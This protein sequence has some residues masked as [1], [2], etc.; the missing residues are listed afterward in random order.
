M[1]N[2]FNIPNYVKYVLN[3][4][5]QSGFNA[6]LV[7]GCVR[8]RLMGLVPK[9]WDITTNALPEQIM[10]IF[11]NCVPTGL[12]HGTVT[13]VLPDK[14]TIEVTTFRIDGKYLDS[15]R[16]EN[17]YFSK[18]LYEDL[19]RRDFTMNAI[20]WSLKEGIVDPF[21]GR[22]DIENKIIRCVGE[23]P[24]RFSEDALRMMRAIRFAAVLNFELHPDIPSAILNLHHLLK[25][26]SAERV[27][28]EFSK[29][30]LSD[31]PEKIYLYKSLELTQYFLPECA[32]IQDD[33][34]KNILA[35]IHGISVSVHDRLAYLLYNFTDDISSVMNRL[36]YDNK[37]CYKVK[38]IAQCLKIRV[39]ENAY[40]MRLMMSD[41]LLR[42]GIKDSLNIRKEVMDQEEKPS[43]IYA[44]ELYDQTL[45]LN[46]CTEISMLAVNGN[47]LENLGIKDGK[48]K[49]RLLK[50]LLDA[51]LV[52]P[53]LNIYESL[54]NI[55]H[56]DYN[57]TS[58]D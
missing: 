2:D 46:H 32:N 56:R 6:Y 43:I 55:L 5:E 53:S 36:K 27:R 47:D 25:N 42:N 37:T 34:L 20:A 45:K 31:N 11:P 54:V 14:N 10:E 21:D 57:Y 18:N 8:D 17:V 49:G 40:E 41:K 1:F 29:T 15:R 9:D 22:G 33:D 7:G 51:T 16:P 58:P 39:P 38:S 35:H 19:S 44:L 28:E 3:G 23:A 13:I 48:E 26:I 30:L 4:I 12:K 50:K 24:K 52:D